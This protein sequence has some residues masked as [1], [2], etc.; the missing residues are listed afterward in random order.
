MVFQFTYFNSKALGEP[1]RMLLSYGN[2]E[3]EDKRVDFQKEW[4]K[5][6]K[7]GTC[8]VFSEDSQYYSIVSLI[9][10]SLG[11]VANLGS[12]WKNYASTYSCLPLPG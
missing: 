12:R 2:I 6:L 4:P 8:N 5:M 3:F 9:S 11:S 7:D 1:I 10:L